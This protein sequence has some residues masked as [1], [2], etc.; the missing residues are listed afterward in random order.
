MSGQLGGDKRASR[1]M[2]PL[3]GRS[4]DLQAF[5]S[6][7]KYAESAAAPMAGAF[8]IQSFGIGRP[9]GG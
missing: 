3:V 6:L 9:A 8:L 7:A 5:S 2:M 1:P 4:T